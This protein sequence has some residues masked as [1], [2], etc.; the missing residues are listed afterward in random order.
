MARVETPASLE[1]IRDAVLLAGREGAG[2]ALCGGR[3]AM[4]GQ[5]FGAGAVLLDLSGHARVRRL[6]SE[7]GLVEADAGIRWPALVGELLE[8]QHSAARVWSI[9]Q[10][11]SGADGLSLGGALAANIHGRGL[12]MAPMVADVE[13]FTLVDARGE[14]RECSRS[15]NAGLFGLAIGGYGLFGVITGVTLRLAPRSPLVR[16]VKIVAVEELMSEFEARI[17][18]GYLFGDWQFAIDETSPDFLRRGVFSC[19]QPAEDGCPV[20]GSP[21]ASLNSADWRRLLFLAHT[22]RRR[23]FAEYARHYLT[24]DGQLYWSDTHQFGV[25]LDGYHAELDRRLGAACPGSEEI[26]E[27]YVPRARLVEFL[28]RAAEALRARRA[29]V[30]YGTVRLIERDAESFLAW[31]REPWACVVFNLHV[32]HAPAPLARAGAAFRALMDEAA[33]LGGSFYLTYGRRAHREQVERCHPRFAEFLAL[34]RRHD[35]GGRWQSDW[36]RHYRKLF[37]ES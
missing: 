8:R 36:L 17:A 20:P 12:A 19:Y 31:A 3:H 2:V 10:K 11:Q 28:G 30:I 37:A 34:Q 1:A 26:A 4:G 14:V 18:A 6:D 32:D 22:D 16:R 13:G 33:A 9:R 35:P 24:T 5:Q 23:A 21:T 27:L 29:T 15:Q 7:H 25:Y